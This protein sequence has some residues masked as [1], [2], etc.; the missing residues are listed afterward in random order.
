MTNDERELLA[1]CVEIGT[2]TW[3]DAMDACGIDGV[4]RGLTRRS[5]QGRFAGYAV[6]ARETA[7]VRG[8][9]Q[10]NAFGV[11]E[12]IGAVGP[13]QVL[14]VDMAGADISTFGGLAALATAKRGAVAVVIDGGCRDIDEMMVSGLWLASRHVTPTTGKTRLKLEG[15]NQPVKLGGIAVAPGD[16]VVGDDTGIVVIPRKEAE[17]VMAE[18]DRMLVIDHQMEQAIGSG[19]SFKDAASD[20]NYIR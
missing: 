6:T 5:G 13:G 3:S 9:F 10:R 15:I 1:R 11:G 4:I 20:A 17:R 7:G 18:A 12:I 8:Q 16:I 19:A 14:M 2:S